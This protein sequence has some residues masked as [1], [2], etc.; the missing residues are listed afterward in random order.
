M[1]IKLSRMRILHDCLETTRKPYI[2]MNILSNKMNCFEN[3]L[4][5]NNNKNHQ[6]IPQISSS[7]LFN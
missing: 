6:N 4:D 1:T 7:Y 2:K 5:M 3:C